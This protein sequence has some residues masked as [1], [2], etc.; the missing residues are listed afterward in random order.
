MAGDHQ[1]SRRAV[2]RRGEVGSQRHLHLAI[3]AITVRGARRSRRHPHHRFLLGQEMKAARA[4]ASLL[5]GVCPPALAAAQEVPALAPTAAASAQATRDTATAQATASAAPS[6]AQPGQ[7]GG[8]TMTVPKTMPPMIRLNSPDQPLS[9][10][11]SAGVSVA[12]QWRNRFT[13]PSVDAD[14]VERF[15]Y[16]VGEPTVVCALAHVCDIALQPGEQISG[17]PNIGDQRWFVHPAVSGAGRT[18]TTHVL[19]KP[20]DAG[21]DTNIVI[22]TDRR[23]Y[24][25]QLI[26][27]VSRYMPLVAF[28]YPGDT[29]AAEWASLSVRQDG[30]GGT[31]CDQPPAIPPSAYRITVKAGNPRWLP[32]QAYAVSTPVGTKTCIEFPS[33]IGSASL[34]ALVALGNDGGWFSEPSKVIINFRYMRRRFVVDDLLDRAE[35]VN[36]IDGN[37]E[38]VKI[39]RID[40]R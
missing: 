9:R 12:T 29:Q 16:G 28:N 1:G 4:F 5:A 14:G 31:P 23:T 37:R 20:I 35:L 40:G 18:R 6:D 22:Q 24:S 19:L 39:T 34:P 25:I 38:L 27:T 11:A 2:C 30:G 26:S 33:D 17:P 10:K 8:A 32:V 7:N 21:M 13:R 36:G 3:P 15:T